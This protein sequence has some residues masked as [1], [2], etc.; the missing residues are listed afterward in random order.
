MPSNTKEEFRVVRILE[1]SRE[2][3]EA[4]RVVQQRLAEEREQLFRQ[5]RQEQEQQGTAPADAPAGVND[6]SR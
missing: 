6:F 4:M 2:E 3:Q 1:V 5:Q